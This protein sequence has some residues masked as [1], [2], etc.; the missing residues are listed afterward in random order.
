[1]FV[2]DVDEVDSPACLVQVN[3]PVLHLVLLHLPDVGLDVSESIN[4]ISSDRSFELSIKPTEAVDLPT[5]PLLPPNH[6]NR[7]RLDE[8]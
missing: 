7:L 6:E 5:P 8:F 3:Q 2:A 4:K 1:M